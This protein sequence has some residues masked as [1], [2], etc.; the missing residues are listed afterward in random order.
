M[1]IRDEKGGSEGSEAGA[2]PDHP[3]GGLD[4]TSLFWCGAR[5]LQ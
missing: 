1:L 2:H 5:A 3:D 4:R